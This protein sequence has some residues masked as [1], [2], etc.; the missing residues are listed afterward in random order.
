MFQKLILFIFTI[1]LF[2]L[3]LF[4]LELLLYAETPLNI[5]EQGVYYSLKSG[6]SVSHLIHDLHKKD[7]LKRPTYVKV[8][9]KLERHNKHIQAG[10]YFFAH[11]LTPLTLIDQLIT[12]HVVQ[13]SIT[14]IEGW[15]F[16]QFIA[17]VLK[18]DELKHENKPLDVKTVMPLLGLDQKHPEGLFLPE[19]YFFSSNTTDIEILKRSHRALMETLNEAWQQRDENLPYKTSYEALIMASII[20]KETAQPTE[21]SIISGV[22]VRRLQKNMRLQTDPTVIYALGEKFDGNI[23]RKDLKLKN[24]Y[25]TYVVKGLPPTPICMVSKA[26]IHAALHPEPGDALYFVSKGNGY[27]Y[28]SSTW[29]EHNRAVRKYQL[30]K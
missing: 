5:P 16:R 9:I 27:H 13:H 26:S 25:N 4:Y 20:E 1:T 23:R 3:F 6:V 10:D 2:L 28:F 21:R 7:I 12:G 17:A 30:K 18:N 29:K 11:G 22:F 8:L 15:N 19:T 24:P 14:F